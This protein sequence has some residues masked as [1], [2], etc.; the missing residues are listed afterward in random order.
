MSE[1]INANYFSPTENDNLL[2][3]CNALMYIFYTF[4]AYTSDDIQVYKRIFTEVI[5]NH[6]NIFVSSIFLSEF[7]NTYIQN[8]YHR[9]MKNNYL[10][11]SKFKFKKDYKPLEDYKETIQDVKNIIIKQILSVAKRIDDPFDKLN[12][13]YFFDNEASF[14]FNDRY[15]ALLAQ[16]YNLKI[17]T[18][19]ADFLY[20]SDVDIITRNQAFFQHRQTK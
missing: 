15:Y 8:E 7:S 9:Y 14:D 1:I 11:P 3:D 16:Y 4:G 6:S 19:D 18:N 5:S 20:I 2:F 17:V 12:L 10:R 13:N